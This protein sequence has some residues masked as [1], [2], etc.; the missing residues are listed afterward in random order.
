MDQ[1]ASIISFNNLLSFLAEN[2]LQDFMETVRLLETVKAANC[3]FEDDKSEFENVKGS[4]G[5]Q[6]NWLT[7]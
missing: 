2:N 5:F 7:D 3:T 4:F 6:I 1:A